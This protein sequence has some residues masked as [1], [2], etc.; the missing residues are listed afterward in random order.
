MENFKT[1]RQLIV[2][3]IVE[4]AVLLVGLEFFN[5]FPISELSDDHM[6]VSATFILYGLICGCGIFTA[7][8][9]G[10]TKDG[11]HIS[12][13]ILLSLFVSFIAPMWPIILGSVM[14]YTIIMLIITRSKSSEP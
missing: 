1:T 10:Q 7:I 6:M 13:L 11:T 9:S 8:K 14:I 5:P 3:L 2:C 4:L 12:E